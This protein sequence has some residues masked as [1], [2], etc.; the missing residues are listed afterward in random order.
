M[1]RSIQIVF[2]DDDIIVVDKPSGA[3]VHPSPGHEEGA[4]CM[5][6]ADR[7]PEMALVGSA[8]RPGVV[9]RLDADTSGVMVFARTQRAYTHLR[10]AFE[11]HGQVKKTYLAIVHG[12]PKTNSGEIETSIGRK[13][14][15]PRRMAVNVPGGKRAIT[16]WTVLERSGTISLVEFKIATGRTHQIR[17]HAAHLGCPIAGDSL[18]GDARKDARMAVRPRRTL[19]HAVEIAFPHPVS[20]RIVRFAVKPP[21]DILFA[22]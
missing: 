14:W 13:P 19:L 2:A 1:A 8:E 16:S 21:P 18:Y 3:Y 12:A 11:K 22:R 10:E 20:G 17:V 15:D 5:E 7:F 4:V 9:H 6:L